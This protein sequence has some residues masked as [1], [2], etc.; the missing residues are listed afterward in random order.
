MGFHNQI[1]NKMTK[2]KEL[3]NFMEAL[4]LERK[5]NLRVA[6]HAKKSR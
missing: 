1:K 3:N 2:Q 4:E 6:N 5:V